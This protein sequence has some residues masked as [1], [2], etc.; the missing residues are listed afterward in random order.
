MTAFKLM[1]AESGQDELTELTRTPDRVLEYSG[2]IDQACGIINLL[3]NLGGY[4]VERVE[5]LPDNVIDRWAFYDKADN[6]VALM[7]IESYETE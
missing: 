3:R 5:K 7:Q 4:E 2:L 6:L 1:Y